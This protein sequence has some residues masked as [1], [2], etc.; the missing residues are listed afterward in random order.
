MQVCRGQAAPAAASGVTGRPSGRTLHELLGVG[1]Q[2][3]VDLVEDRVDVVVEV[4][5]AL[6]DVA[7][8]GRPPRG[9]L[10]ALS[11]ALL[12][13]AWLLLLLV[14][15]PD[16]PI[17]WA[18]QPVRARCAEATPCRGGS[19]GSAR[20]RPRRC[21]SGRAARRRAPWCPAAGRASGTR[22]SDSRPGRSKITESQDAAATGRRTSPG[23][24]PGSRPGCPPAARAS[25]LSTSASVDQPLDPA[26]GRP[27]GG[28]GP[29]RGARRSTGGR[30][31]AAWRRP[32]RG[33]R[34]RGTARAA[35]SLATQSSSRGA[36]HRVALEPVEHRLPARQHVAVCASAR[37]RTGP[38]RTC[39]PGR[40]TPA[41]AGPR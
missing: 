36:Q 12:L 25:R 26:A 22:C 10:A 37:R 39:G 38:R 19:A 7:L 11:S 15:C 2:H 24:G 4:F 28:R 40:G 29:S 1:L 18:E 5:L 8:G 14:P 41:A 16:D 35:C 9:V 27:A 21:R 32:S 34:G 30:S 23:S 17:D 3:A 20:D 31:A 33:R 13:L 6:G